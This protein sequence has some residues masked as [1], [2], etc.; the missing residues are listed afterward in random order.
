MNISSLPKPS[1]RNLY[2]GYPPLGKLFDNKF[3]PDVDEKE[4]FHADEDS[5]TFANYTTQ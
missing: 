1:A 4:Q 3:C 2:A 5:E